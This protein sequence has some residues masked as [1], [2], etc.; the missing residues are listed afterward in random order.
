MTANTARNF[1]VCR[2]FPALQFGRA[3][4]FDRHLHAAPRSGNLSLR[5]RSRTGDT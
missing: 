3:A 4:E 1:P 2:I 5:E